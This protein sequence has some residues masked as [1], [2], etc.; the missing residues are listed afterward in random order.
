MEAIIEKK[1]TTTLVL[2]HFE[3]QWLMALMQNP[4]HGDPKTEG[5]I[6]RQMRKKFW[7]ALNNQSIL[8]PF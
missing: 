5:K 8:N 6:D 3:T 7:D 1:V 4:I 2:D